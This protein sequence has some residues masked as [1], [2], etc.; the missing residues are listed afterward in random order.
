MQS[1]TRTTPF[2]CNYKEKDTKIQ[3]TVFHFPHCI[4]LYLLKG[5]TTILLWQYLQI[6][7]HAN[8]AI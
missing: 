8:K 5:S 7:F 6:V 2:N 1:G 4:V 3:S